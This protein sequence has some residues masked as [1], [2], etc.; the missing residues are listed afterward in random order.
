M[1]NKMPTPP[2]A[3]KRPVTLSNHGIERTD[4]Y[5]WLR[6]DN[7]QEVM[8][9]PSVLADDIR[10]YLEAENDYTNAYFEDTTALQET[11]FEEMKARIKEDDSSVPSKDGDYAYSMRYVT[12]GQQPHFL[13]TALDGSNE[14]VLLDGDALAEGKAYFRL[15]GLGHSDD[16][17]L[18]IWSFDD[19]G[20]EYFTLRVR[21]L[22][23]GEDLADE[24]TETTGGGVWDNA[25]KSFFYVKQDENHRPSK[26]FRHV[27]GD[28]PENDQLIYEEEDPGFFVGV[29]K[30]SANR[31]ITIDCHDHQTAE[32]YLIDADNP[33]SAP[34]LVAKREIEIEYSVDD[35]DDTRLI[36]STNADDAADIKLVTAPVSDPSRSNWEDYVAYEP[37]RLIKSMGTYK[38]HLV[39]LEVRSALPR[40]VIQRLSDGEEHAI[41]FDE[42]AYSLGLSGGYEYDTTS[43]RFSYSSMTTPGQTYDY[44]METR[45]RVLRKEQE[46]PSGHDAGDYVT[47]RLQAKSH[48]GVDVP[49]SIVHRKDTP[50]DGS[51]PLLL[52]GYGSYGMSMPASFSTT[53]LSLVDRGFVYAIAHIRGGMEKGDAWYKAGKREHKENTFKDFISAGHH[54]ANEGYTSKG[55]IIS[56]GGSA[57]GMLMGAIVNME[58]SLFGGCIAAVPFVDVLTT[59]LDD[60]LPLTPPEW[61]EWGN[62]IES[63]E[64]YKTI[65]A[66][67]PV[68]NVSAQAYPPIFALAG[69]TDPRVTYWEPAKWVAKLRE[70]KSDDNILMLK[71]NMDSGHSGASGR[72]DSL[73]ET[74]QEYAFAL[75]VMGSFN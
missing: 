40:I 18:G 36:I 53:R 42:E 71:T 16:H 17:K 45:E 30:T 14:Q 46:I 13:R 15:G 11:L 10:G 66:Y 1:T 65:A 28:A 72:F 35:L 9:D 49:I 58:P 7:W 74:A 27:I 3:E 26:V 6:A 23:T 22:A 12:G 2:K 69:L 41:S 51:A 33:E 67:S 75:K 61:P 62:P 60:T 20:S 70:H 37:G 48:D 50:L 32:V 47:R 8:R 21:D 52:Y 25:S 29:G 39:W 31:F 64:D 59:M 55:K 4:D 38:N 73:K 19:K 68:D 24:I 54:L 57:G 56:H 34:R 5:A 43:I 63:T 44:D